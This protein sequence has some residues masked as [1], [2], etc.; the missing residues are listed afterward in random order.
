MFLKVTA[1]YY[2]T[3]IR[4]KDTLCEKLSFAMEKR[5]CDLH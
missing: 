5:F 1:A 4:H 2:A 3:C